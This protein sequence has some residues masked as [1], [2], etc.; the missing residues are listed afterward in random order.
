MY[1][2]KFVM[3]VFSLFLFMVIVVVQLR[4]DRYFLS[5]IF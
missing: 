4:W 3:L 5:N 2:E 1:E